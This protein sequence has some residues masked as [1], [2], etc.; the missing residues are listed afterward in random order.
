MTEP[1]RLSS[2]KNRRHKGGVTEREK[3]V[4]KSYIIRIYRYQPGRPRKV[5]G[6]VEKPES[7][8]KQPFT[9]VNELWAILTDVLSKGESRVESRNPGEMG[10]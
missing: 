3:D 5:V 9:N 8:E 6:I 1:G 2:M 4:V 10:K 7:S